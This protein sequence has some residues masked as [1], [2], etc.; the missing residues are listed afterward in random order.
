MEH[1][2]GFEPMSW[3]WQCQILDLTRPAML[4]LLIKDWKVVELIQ[5]RVFTPSEIIKIHPAKI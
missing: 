4:N 2:S 3:Q 5:T 1:R